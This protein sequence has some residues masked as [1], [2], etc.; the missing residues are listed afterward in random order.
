MMKKISLFIVC[1]LVILTS[2]CKSAAYHRNEAAESA[3]VFLLKNAPELTPE[4]VCFVKYNDPVLL[5]APV[6]GNS[7]KGS[8]FEQTDSVLHQICIAWNIPGASNLYIVFGVSD[9]RMTTWQPLR[10]IRKD[11]SQKVLPEDAAV[12]YCRKYAQDNLLHTLTPSELN[13][14]RFEYPF[15][16]RT[17]FEL[18][19]NETGKMTA[20][21]IA[22][23]KEAAAGKLQY[24]LYWQYP[25]GSAAVFCGLAAADMTGWTLNFAGKIGKE[26]LVKHLIGVVR[27]P[28][29][30]NDN[31]AILKQDQPAPDTA[32]K[33]K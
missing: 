24:S 20:E 17:G 33:N 22:A 28:A 12:F 10:L 3:R 30:A 26:E 15:I 27:T 11:F 6:L 29:Q 9:A 4:Q 21:E 7:G 1:S 31:I 19:F 14:V 13:L 18:N 23:V 8:D 16:A 5:T 25:D 32:E 2:G